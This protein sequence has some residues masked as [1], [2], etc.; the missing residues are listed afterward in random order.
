MKGASAITDRLAGQGIVAAG[1]GS[2]GG[3]LVPWPTNYAA[4][5]RLTKPM[6][7]GDARAA[8]E[9]AFRDTFTFTAEITQLWE[10]QTGAVRDVTAGTAADLKADTEAA[11]DYTTPLI[12]AVSVG[13]VAVAVIYVASKVG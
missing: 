6:D 1:A 5:V 8:I 2:G 7:D 13:L 9:Q 11:L 12:A 10:N 3:W 4:N